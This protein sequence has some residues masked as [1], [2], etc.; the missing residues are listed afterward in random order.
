M[1]VRGG[2]PRTSDLVDAS[3]VGLAA[4]L[5]VWFAAI[6]PSA[7]SH[8]STVLASAVIAGTTVT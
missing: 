7:A 5:I 6:A 3:I 8:Q 1:L 4:G 2:R